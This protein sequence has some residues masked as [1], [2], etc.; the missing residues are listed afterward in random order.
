MEDWA[1]AASWDKAHTKPCTPNTYN[2]Y[3]TDRTIYDDGTLRTFNM[4]VE[5]SDQKEPPASTLGTNQDL[6]SPD[7]EGNGHISRNIRLCLLA[8]DVVQPYV[9]LT[10]VNGIN[11]TDL[12]AMPLVKKGVENCSSAAVQIP[13][14]DIAAVVEWTV[15]GAFD[16]D[17]T[18]LVYGKHD[19]M[20]DSGIVYCTSQPDPQRLDSWLQKIMDQAEMINETTNINMGK[21]SKG[22][23]FQFTSAQKGR[24]R[25]HEQGS[26]PVIQQHKSQHLGYLPLDPKFQASIDLSSFQPGDAVMVF[27]VA[28]V[29]SSWST[30]ISVAQSHMVNARTNDSWYFKNSAGMFIQG[31]A[32]WMS[33]PV[34]LV[35]ESQQGEWLKTSEEEIWSNIVPE[36]PNITGSFTDTGKGVTHLVS[37]IHLALLCLVVFASV[38]LMRWR[39]HSASNRR[40]GGFGHRKSKRRRQLRPDGDNRSQI[41]GRDIELET[42]RLGRDI[43]YTELQWESLQNEEIDDHNAGRAVDL[44]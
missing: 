3:P 1:Y 14:S 2:N 44:F 29:D 21:I 40:N 9:Y 4:L 42:M 27:A 13:N 18:Y 23:S 28:V 33:I 20:L 24:T 30:S 5:T 11:V 12:D 15:G 35:V 17:E 31:H 39:L 7:G 32:R 41:N 8:I 19:D 16:V 43:D 36:T 25:W 6:F 26:S 10:D 38:L 34:V 22:S 37:L